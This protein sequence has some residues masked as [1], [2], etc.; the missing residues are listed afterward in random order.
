MYAPNPH[1]NYDVALDGEHL[2]LLKAANE[3]E[4]TVITNWTHNLRAH[5]TEHATP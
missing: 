1:A 4:M 3:G 2:V 5:V